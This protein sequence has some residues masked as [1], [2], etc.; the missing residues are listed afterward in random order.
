MRIYTT[1][2]IHLM[3]ENQ[4]ISDSDVYA[5]FE[6]E[7]GQITFTN[8]DITVWEDD[9]NTYIDVPFTQDQTKIFKVGSVIAIEVNWY[10]DGTRGATDISYIKVTDNL[11]K[12]ILS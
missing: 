6:H 1:P 7:D 9:G 2:I 12:E 11:L 3:V 10:K 8:D 5:T 4:L